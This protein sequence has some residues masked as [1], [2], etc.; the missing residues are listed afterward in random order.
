[1]LIPRAIA[2]FAISV[3]SPIK[4]GSTNSSDFKRA[5]APK[6]LGSVASGKT[7]LI[8]R[9]TTLN[10]KLSNNS[11][12]NPPVLYLQNPSYTILKENNSFF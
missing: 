12:I 11:T 6:I 8:L 3:G 5:A 4:I 1:M 2:A 10:F 9:R 7:I